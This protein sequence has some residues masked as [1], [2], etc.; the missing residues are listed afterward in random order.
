MRKQHGQA[1]AELESSAD[2]EVTFRRDPRF[3]TWLPWKISEQYEGA[4]PVGTRSPMPSNGR[5]CHELRVLDVSANWRILYH[6]A[7]DAVVILAVFQKKPR[8]RRCQ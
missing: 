8:R 3:D 4:I 2:I 1:L 6:V 5:A 7:V